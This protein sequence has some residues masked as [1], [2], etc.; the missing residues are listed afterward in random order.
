MCKIFGLN[1]VDSKNC[2]AEGVKRQEK[3]EGV[4]WGIVFNVPFQ[5]PGKV[6]AMLLDDTILEVRVGASAMGNSNFICGM[7]IP[8]RSIT[9]DTGV[10]ARKAPRVKGVW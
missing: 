5:H 1:I 3:E 9:G 4:K 8:I 10:L 2:I 7:P 6:R